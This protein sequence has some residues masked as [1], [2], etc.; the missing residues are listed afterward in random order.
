ME[1][2]VRGL[3]Q[4]WGHEILMKNPK[5]LDEAISISQK[6]EEFQHRTA[7]TTTARVRLVEEENPQALDQSIANIFTNQREISDK[8]NKDWTKEMGKTKSCLKNS[9]KGMKDEL[10]ALY[11]QVFD[12]AYGAAS[13][14][15]MFTDL[16]GAIGKYN[17]EMGEDC[18]RVKEVNGKIAVALCTPLMK[19]VHQKHKY[20]GELVF[21]DA[22]GGMDRYDCRIFMMLTHS[23]AGGLPLG[24]LIVTSKSREC[25]TE[26]LRLYL[27]IVP[28]DAFFGRGSRGPI[29]FLSDDSEA[30]RQSLEE[31][32]PE[33]TLVLCVFHLLQAIWRFLWEG[34]NNIRKDHRP[35]LLFLVKK[36]T[37]A[38]SIEDLKKAYAELQA[39][40][41]ASR[42]PNY[43]AHCEK[44]HERRHAWAVCYRHDLPV[45]GNNTNNYAEAAMRIL[46]DQIFERVRAYNVVQL[47]DFFVTRMNA[48][49]ERR[50]T[51]LSNG[52]ID[53]TISRRY[54]PGGTS[55]PKNNVTKVDTHY[56]R[57]KS[58]TELDVD[59]F[60]DM[61]I[62][63]CTCAAG[64]HGAPCK[65][66]Y[67]V[68][69]HFNESSLNFLPLKD[70]QM[71]KHLLFLATGQERVR[72]GW[73]SSLPVAGTSE[74]NDSDHGGVPEQVRPDWLVSL[75]VASSSGSNDT[76]S[77]DKIATLESALNECTS[78][79]ITMLKQ[80]PEE[81]SE[82]I[83]AYLKQFNSLK[84]NSAFVSAL[85]TFGKYTGAA[86]A[87]SNSKKSKL[88]RKMGTSIKVQPTAVSRRTTVVGGRRC[89]HTGRKVTDTCDT[90]SKKRNKFKLEIEVGRVFNLPNAI[91]KSGEVWAEKWQHRSSQLAKAS[92]SCKG[93]IEVMISKLEENS[94]AYQTFTWTSYVALEH[95]T[96]ST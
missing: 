46:K 53:V 40:A 51:D 73:F 5:N 62:A 87:L 96:F 7:P 92:P 45:R 41:I 47:L 48:Y 30:E 43:L 82:P 50:L 68:V 94:Q 31:V 90:D 18:G 89:V 20:S 79:L 17:G 93:I 8:H 2:F 84:T 55:I 13:G 63:T 19:R 38:S 71:R 85:K 9:M 33:A 60:V 74:S 52:R 44:L 15:K 10:L 28:N 57:I 4:K 16:E 78:H 32:F 21:I 95:I 39:N 64:M 59:Y 83:E 70:P 67:A 37:F 23:A 66:Q 77:V 29:V 12:K 24:C 81:F 76:A 54:L 35:D 11:R 91:K 65:H 14:K 6:L 3:P 25:I 80:D 36:M 75:P 72:P 69:N 88:C 49:Y 86:P 34:K 26:A 22:S 42:Y 27:D 56:Y 58:Q 1:F 61:S